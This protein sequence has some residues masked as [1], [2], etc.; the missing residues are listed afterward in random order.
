LLRFA[1]SLSWRAA[2]YFQEMNNDFF[3]EWDQSK[4]YKIWKKYLLERKDNVDPYTIH[5]FV[6]KDQIKFPHTALGGFIDRENSLLLTQIGPMFFVSLM[7]PNILTHDEMIIWNKSKISHRGGT[8]EVICRLTNSTNMPY[9]NNMTPKLQGTFLRLE[10][11]VRRAAS[12][13]NWPGS[14]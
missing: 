4:S 14:N 8:L 10:E 13:G 6:L 5:L 9:I 12:S 2:K 3:I 11:T 1:V 7:K